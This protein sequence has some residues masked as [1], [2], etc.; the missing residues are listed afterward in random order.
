VCFGF[1]TPPEKSIECVVT[2][3]DHKCMIM[4]LDIFDEKKP[5]SLKR[6]EP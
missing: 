1:F 5:L 3:C 4:R 6:N 2:E